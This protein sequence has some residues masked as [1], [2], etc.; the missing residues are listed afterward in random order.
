[1]QKNYH[2][3]EVVV[4]LRGEPQALCGWHINEAL[5]KL[6]NNQQKD[7]QNQ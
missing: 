4:N 1:M 5:E 3:V 6:F 7:V 2:G